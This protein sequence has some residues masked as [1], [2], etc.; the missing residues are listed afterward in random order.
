MELGLL[1]STRCGS[2]LGEPSVDPVIRVDTC[3]RWTDQIPVDDVYD[4]CLSGRTDSWS[5]YGLHGLYVDRVAGREPDH[6]NNL[7]Y[8]CNSTCFL[9]RGCVTQILRDI[10]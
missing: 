9:L 6:L 7:L 1:R 2:P 10:S 4:L 3:T 8:Y 5:I